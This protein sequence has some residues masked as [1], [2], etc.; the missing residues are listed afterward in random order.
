MFLAEGLRGSLRYRHF[1]APGRRFHGK[2]VPVALALA[3]TE[4]RIVAYGGVAA[5]KLMDTAFGDSRLGAVTAHAPS[6]GDQVDF[7]IDY[8]ALG[9]PGV[10]GEI[11]IRVRTADAEAVAEH[12]RVR[13]HTG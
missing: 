11:T 12:F 4:R 13:A 9:E 10:S 3:I 8:D 7:V 6:G 5:G 1:R 2:V